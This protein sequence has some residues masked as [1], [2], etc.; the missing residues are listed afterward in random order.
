MM[1]KQGSYTTVISTPLGRETVAAWKTSR[2]ELRPVL[3]MTEKGAKRLER[4]KS[5][6]YN[7][8][9]GRKQG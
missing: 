5:G 8:G 9:R 1:H 7:G 4:W 3:P 6:N 2:G